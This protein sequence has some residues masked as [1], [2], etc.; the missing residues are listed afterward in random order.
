MSLGEC[1]RNNDTALYYTQVGIH[2]THSKSIPNKHSVQSTDPWHKD[3]QQYR[4][5]KHKREDENTADQLPVWLV[6]EVLICWFAGG[7]PL[8]WE[9]LSEGLNDHCNVLWSGQ[10]VVSIL[11]C[12][13]WHWALKPNRREV[14]HELA[15]DH[16]LY[17]AP[18]WVLDSV[19]RATTNSYFRW[20]ACRDGTDWYVRL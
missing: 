9:Q 10:P 20:K 12:S 1:T 19:T 17:A 15:S 13:E 16:S 18:T 4:K 5:K 2:N 6:L 14:V 8:W 3:L 11:N 7:I